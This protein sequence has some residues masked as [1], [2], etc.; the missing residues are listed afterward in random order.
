MVG[1]ERVSHGKTM[2]KPRPKREESS[3][4]KNRE[5]YFPE[6]GIVYGKTIDRKEHSVFNQLKGHICQEHN[7]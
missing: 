2:L 6:R 5:T 4:E 1:R 3:F 7:E